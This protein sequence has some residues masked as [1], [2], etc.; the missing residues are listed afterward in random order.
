MPIRIFRLILVLIAFYLIAATGY[1]LHRSFTATKSSVAL[2]QAGENSLLSDPEAATRNF[3][4]SQQDAE[5]SL[6]IIRNA[7]WWD[8]LLSLIPPLRWQV[9]LAKASYSLAQAGQS[10]IALQ[11]SLTTLSQAPSK[12]DDPLI[13]TG[14][15]Y[16]EWYAAEAPTVSLLQ[17]QLSEAKT[18]FEPIPDWIFLSQSDNFIRLQKQLEELTRAISSD[19]RTGD[20]VLNLARHSKTAFIILLP[21]GPADRGSLGTL[22]LQNGRIQALTFV[23]LPAPLLAAYR[24]GSQRDAFWPQTARSLALQLAGGDEPAG[25]AAVI[26]PSLIKDL[27]RISGPLQLPGVA[28]PTVTSS[29]WNGGQ[30]SPGQLLGQLSISLL[31]PERKLDATS[32][33]KLSLR[34]QSLQIW[35][36]DSSLLPTLVSQPDYAAPTGH[37]NWLRILPQSSEGLSATVKQV[38]RT[39]QQDTLQTLLVTSSASAPHVALPSAAQ[40]EDG[41]AVAIRSG[42]L[43]ATMRPFETGYS[44]RYSLPRTTDGPSRILYLA[45]LSG[46]QKVTAFGQEKLITRDAILTP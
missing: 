43:E 11:Q 32:S 4:L 24:T 41:S 35:S 15:R 13:A 40:I 38:S 9:Q 46:T 39:L 31:Q 2:L 45:P 30:V 21:A 5:Q 44:L 36:S 19:R 23:P 25:A 6:G 26:D 7:R 12:S 20:G 17:A 29:D 28:N 1:L 27:L 16:L 18:N 22:S 37:S 8:R 33:L 3:Q 14:N 42:Y 10:T 34:N